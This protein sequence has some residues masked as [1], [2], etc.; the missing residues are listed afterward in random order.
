MRKSTQLFKPFSKLLFAACS[1]ATIFNVAA[2]AQSIE[3][4]FPTPISASEISGRIVARDVGDPRLTRYFYILNGTPGDLLITV[5]S[6][7]LNGD[8]DLF[9][10][11]TLRPLA[12]VS[13]YAAESSTK[14]T[15]SIFLKQRQQIILRIEA[16][17]A[18]D[19]EGVY[20]IR[21]EGSFE[22]LPEV[23]PTSNNASAPR[24]PEVAKTRGGTRVSSSGARLPEE[25]KEASSE[26]Q[27]AQPEPSP[28]PTV[29]ESATVPEPVTTARRAPSTPRRRTR[30]TSPAS[31]NARNRRPRVKPSTPNNSTPDP[32]SSASNASPETPESKRASEPTTLRPPIAAAPPRLVIEFRSGVKTERSMTTVRRVTIDNNQLVIVNRDGKIERQQLADVLRFSIE[33]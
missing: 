10:A 18:N 22:P 17:S 2:F 7:N 19:N 3:P 21:F 28:T 6:N 13:M 20:R 30:P 26:P 27:P 16:R 15:K 9:T 12:K 24:T 29:T 33:P 14:A 32:A 25:V 5:E 11:G 4:D 8:V 31:T 23:A 1:L